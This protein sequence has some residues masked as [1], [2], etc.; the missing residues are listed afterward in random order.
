MATAKGIHQELET[1][2]TG[3]FSA[4]E[5]QLPMFPSRF[6]IPFVDNITSYLGKRNPFSHPID[7]ATSTVWLLNN[8]AW[9]NGRQWTAE[10]CVAYFRKDSGVALT[11]A[12]ADVAS[13]LGIAES[14]TATRARMRKRLQPFVDSILPAKTVK[15]KVNG[16]GPLL[17]LGPSGRD[18]ISEDIKAFA[19]GWKGGE[20][21]T[22]TLV[23]GAEVDS[24]DIQGKTYF[25]EPDGW[26]I[27]SDIDDTIKT[28]LTSNPLGILRTTFAEEARVIPGMPE[29]YKTIHSLL[30]PHWFYLSASPYNLYP[31]LYEF[32]YGSFPQGQVVLRDASWMDLAGFLMSLT[33]G[34]QNYKV[35][36]MDKMHTWFPGRK[37]IC[38][39]DSTQTD[40][41]AYAEVYR[42]YP[43]WIKRIFIR[44]VTDVAEM[45]EG[46]KNK[47]ERFEAAFEGVPKEVWTLFEKPEELATAVQAISGLA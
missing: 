19:G 16:D 22:N 38:V 37:V 15:A 25:A 39:G 31:F 28:T 18:G 29:L 11:S 4:T 23:L 47:D 8:S 13:T 12:V 26:M 5:R 21:I 33:A 42:K 2:S 30:D 40:P 1:R 43:G 14:D 45:N 10:F 7:F 35:S 34:T 36:R 46:D 3:N 9:R 20:Q 24:Q 44:K 6:S 17:K 32:V 27:I 41:E